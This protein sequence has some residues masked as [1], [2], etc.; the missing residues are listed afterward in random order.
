MKISR[1][2]FFTATMIAAGMAGAYGAETQNPDKS[3]CMYA[4]T[5]A[6]CPMICTKGCKENSDCPTSP[7][8]GVIVYQKDDEIAQ[9]GTIGPNATQCRANC[10]YPSPQVRL[11][12]TIGGQLYSQSY[13]V[14]VVT[15]PQ[16]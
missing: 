2:A 9:L 7:Q 1:L 11:N 10:D 4:T 12:I 13:Y 16:E 3:K 14:H 6:D 8:I 5:L 15:P